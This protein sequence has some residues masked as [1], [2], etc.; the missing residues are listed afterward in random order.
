[1]RYDFAIYKANKLYCLLEYDGG[2]HRSAKQMYGS[3]IEEKE[4]NFKN[5]VENDKLK[6]EYAKRNNILL[7]R[8]YIRNIK[9]NKEKLKDCLKELNII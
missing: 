4:K 3:T 5:I 6:N 7:Y 8:I 2:Q 9:K 1:M